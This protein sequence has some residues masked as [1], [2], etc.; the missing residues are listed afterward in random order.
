MEKTR[1][2][3]GTQIS[4]DV[5]GEGPLV[6]LVGGAFNDRNTW[7]DL[8][9]A[10]AKRGYS[11]VSYDRRGRGDSTDARSYA[12][13]L[14]VDDLRAV[15]QSVS[16][17]GTALA[18]GTSSGGALVLRAVAAGVSVTKA[19]ILEAPF[20]VEGAPPAP[21]DYL[22]T[23]DS[24]IASGDRSGAVEYFMTEAVGLP[25]EA[26]AQNKAHPMWA[27]FERMAHTLVYDAH[28]LG[29]DDH[30]LPSELLAG[31]AIPVLTVSST[32]SAP[33][34]RAAAQGVADAAPNAH[35]RTLD[36]VFHSVPPEVLA[37]ALDDFYR[38][39]S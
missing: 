31:I 2:A 20:R 35:H 19:T 37:P 24:F 39:A 27:H 36:G 25:A 1:S 9:Q 17:D 3:D 4:Y 32:A 8:A 30:G 34:L 18:H 26:V 23:L 13:E 16:G 21:V 28:L 38:S 11:A 15:I 6:V 29:G 12:V 5:W 7:T 10:L 14:E 33:W 22:A